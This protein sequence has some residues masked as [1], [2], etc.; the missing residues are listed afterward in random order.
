MTSTMYIPLRNVSDAAPSV[1]NE[2]STF[3]QFMA[4][5]VDVRVIVNAYVYANLG[6]IRANFARICPRFAFA[7]VAA[8]TG[9][10][11]NTNRAL[12][13]YHGHAVYG[14]GVV[15]SRRDLYLIILEFLK[16]YPPFQPIEKGVFRTKWLFWVPIFSLSFKNSLNGNSQRV[17]RPQGSQPPLP[18]ISAGRP[19]VRLASPLGPTPSGTNRVLALSFLRASRW[20]FWGTRNSWAPRA[21]LPRM[22]QSLGSFMLLDPYLKT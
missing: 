15:F 16:P 10:R 9:E 22:I 5:E 8:N 6:Q 11:H 4:G 3:G 20:S 7:S 17:H 2:H 1:D 19:L 13:G 18:G 14:K 21:P 12:N